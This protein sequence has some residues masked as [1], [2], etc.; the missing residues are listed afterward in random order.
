MAYMD[1]NIDSDVKFTII[2]FPPN[3]LFVLQW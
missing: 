1:F 3:S 2:T